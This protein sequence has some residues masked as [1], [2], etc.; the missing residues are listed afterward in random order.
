MNKGKNLNESLLYFNFSWESDQSFIDKYLGY[1]YNR[2]VA[3]KIAEETVYLVL[4]GY[5]F[6]VFNRGLDKA[7]IDS[8]KSLKKVCIQDPNCESIKSIMEREFDIFKDNKIPFQLEKNTAQFL[9]PFELK[10]SV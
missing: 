5:S 10:L 9:I 3:I 7:L 1:N 8:M 4:I 6:P 2:E